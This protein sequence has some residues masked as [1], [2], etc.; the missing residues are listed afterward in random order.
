MKIQVLG[1]ISKQRVIYHVYK[2]LG[3]Y[4]QQALVSI[5]IG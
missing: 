2:K 4:C 5:G 1:R 3:I